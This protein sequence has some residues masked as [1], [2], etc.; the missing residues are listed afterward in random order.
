[1]NP[2]ISQ[3]TST[4]NT[5]RELNQ[6][7]ERFDQ[8]ATTSGD[9]TSTDSL[10]PKAITTRPMFTNNKKPPI[11]QRL[12]HISTA[13]TVATSPGTPLDDRNAPFVRECSVQQQSAKAH[14]GTFDLL[15]LN[16][17]F[18]NNHSAPSWQNCGQSTR[19]L[20]STRS[21]PKTDRQPSTKHNVY[22]RD[23]CKQISKGHLT[24]SVKWPSDHRDVLGEIM[25]T[26]CFDSP[27]DF[28]LKTWPCRTMEK[29]EKSRLGT[30]E[31]TGSK[32]RT[33]VDAA[34]PWAVDSPGKD[35]LMATKLCRRCSTRLGGTA[36]QEFPDTP[37]RYSSIF[38]TGAQLPESGDIEI[39]G[40]DKSRIEKTP[41]WPDSVYTQCLDHGCRP[42]SLLGPGG[43]ISVQVIKSPED[44]HEIERGRILHG[45]DCPSCQ[46]KGLL[47]DKLGAANNRKV[48]SPEQS[49]I[50]SS[51]GK[52][53]HSSV[54]QD[55]CTTISSIIT[56][57]CEML[58]RIIDCLKRSKTGLSST[59]ELLEV[60]AIAHGPELSKALPPSTSRRQTTSTANDLLSTS[61]KEKSITEVIDLIDNAAS[62]FSVNQNKEM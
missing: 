53:A 21:E 32:S 41:D 49:A 35:H 51:P 29:L 40:H 50:K 13:A 5:S 27:K 57:N 38:A 36:F 3:Y 46:S 59:Q 18:I 15:S 2:L 56:D 17:S 16:S 54:A 30:W 55:V 44:I 25:S 7:I 43:Q 34:S 33:N 58:D 20:C 47:F 23:L 61:L 62:G 60:L 52:P 12:S 31:P 4:V 11:G 45:I 19:G 1:M 9:I 6:H 39:P 37:R 10:T 28:K 42:Q 26:A 8:S 22:A 24:P 48:I 14:C